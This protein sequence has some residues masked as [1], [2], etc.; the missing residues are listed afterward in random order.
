MKNFYDIM[1]YLYIKQ[2][3][4]IRNQFLKLKVIIKDKI[5]LLKNNFI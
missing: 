2:W 5:H 4:I 1:N 3:F